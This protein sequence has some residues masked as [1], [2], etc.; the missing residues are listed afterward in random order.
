MPRIIYDEA[1]IREVCNRSISMRD[2]ARELGIKECTL[3]KIAEPLGCY[4]PHKYA[5]LGY[6]NSHNRL[7]RERIEDEILSNARYIQAAQLRKLLIRVGIKD[8][9]CELCGVT[10]WRGKPAP[11]ELHHKDF[12]RYNNSLDNLQILCPNCHASLTDGSH[13]TG[14]E[15]LREILTVPE[16]LPGSTLTKKKRRRSANTP[17]TTCK[18]CGKIFKSRGG[19]VHCS[20]TCRDKAADAR[21][22]SADELRALLSA[23]PNY[24]AAGTV[25][26]VSANAVKKWCKRRGIIDEV[27]P[28]IDEERRLRGKSAADRQDRKLAA[29]KAAATRSQNIDYFVKYLIVDGEEVEV[30]RYSTVA[31]LEAA[32]Y[33]Y[34]VASRAWSGKQEK[35]RGYI[36]RRESK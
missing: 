29:K 31:E 4:D 23:N 2:A 24:T 5:R 14:K 22:P 28:L 34:D 36:W 21:I 35:Y 26:N 6:V 10:E 8:K 30:A 33:N 25:L 17:Q 7:T 11:L 18:W 3:K 15:M 32:G 19:A 1:V 12:N 13:Q 20:A 9:R 27:Q 16:Q